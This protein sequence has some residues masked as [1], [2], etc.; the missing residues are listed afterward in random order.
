MT[1]PP[2][3]PCSI[4]NCDSCFV[5]PSIGS[6][7][8]VCMLHYYTTGVHRSRHSRSTTAETGNV[9]KNKSS[10]FVD[11]NRLEKQ[12]PQV[13]E[14]FAE[15]FVELQREIGEESAR[16][17]QLAATADDP[18]ALLLN[19]SQ[20]EILRPF[21]KQYPGHRKN[22]FPQQKS[23]N[24]DSEGGF[25]REIALPDRLRMLQNPKDLDDFAS[26]YNRK[27]TDSPR[28]RTLPVSDIAVTQP[29]NPYHRKQKPPIN[30]WNQVLDASDGNDN[31]KKKSKTKWEDMEKEM[32]RDITSGSNA[33]SKL[34]TCGS[35]DV[36]IE[37]TVTSR[38]NDMMKGE[39]WGMKDRAEMIVERLHCLACGK[40][41]NE[42]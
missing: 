40:T 38:N 1:A 11:R 15:A 30:V 18:L 6:Q 32:T 19:S 41:W 17:F 16:S 2:L 42:E 26:R 21:R 36:E 10:L 33:S 9:S 20:G 29:S 34:C 12:L 7:Q 3:K 23:A 5:I 27:S 28:K 24:D 8:Y 14:L 37:G 4:C 13:Q 25:I 31:S 22:N 35:K 39:V